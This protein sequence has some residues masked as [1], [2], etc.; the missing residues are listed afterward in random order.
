MRD[1]SKFYIANY[2]NNLRYTQINDKKSQDPALRGVL[3]IVETGPGLPSTPLFDAD[4]TCEMIIVYNL[5][6]GLVYGVHLLDTLVRT[7]KIK[8]AINTAV[9]LRLMVDLANAELD[10]LKNAAQIKAQLERKQETAD[11]GA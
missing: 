1:L 5:P 8:N 9:A 11:A 10:R 6:C 3:A 4:R 2:F 7:K